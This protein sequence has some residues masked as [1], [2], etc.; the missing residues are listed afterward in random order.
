MPLLILF[1]PTGAG[2]TYIGKLLQQ[3]FGYHFYDGDSDLT[4]EMKRALNSM[5]VITD[6]MRQKFITKLIN[7]TV[8]LAVQHHQLAVAQTFIKEKYRLR[9][10]KRLPPARFILVKTKT[11]IRYVR[12]QQRADYPWNETYVKKMDMLFEAPKIPHQII[13]NDS[14]GSDSLKFSLQ[15]LI[16]GLS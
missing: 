5:Q 3:N 11:N 13:T 15:Q 14:T 1:G 4:E 12:R 16:S 2:K 10:L 9:L 8:K 6:R 7:S